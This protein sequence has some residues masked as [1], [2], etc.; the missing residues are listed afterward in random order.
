MFIIVLHRHN[1]LEFIWEFCHEIGQQVMLRDYII[2][3]IP[4][5]RAF[6]VFKNT[7]FFQVKMHFA[8]IYAN[9]ALD[10]LFI[11]RRIKGCDY[12]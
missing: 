5:L 6:V 1:K 11:Y 7:P 2:F 10:S 8:R 9:F 4:G 3:Y 12:G